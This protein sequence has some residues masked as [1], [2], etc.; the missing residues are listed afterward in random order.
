MAEQKRQSDDAIALLNVQLGMEVT[1]RKMTESQ[2]DSIIQQALDRQYAL[3]VQSMREEIAA[4][5]GNPFY[6]PVALQKLEDQLADI[7][8]QHQLAVSKTIADGLK[9]DEQRFNQFFNSINGD[10][11][12]MAN[13]M[14]SGQVT[15]GQ[16]FTRLGVQMEQA[17]IQALEK[18]VLKWVEQHLF[19]MITHQAWLAQLLGLDSANNATKQ[20][21]GAI[22]A[23]AAVTQQA[24]VAG[25]AAFA[26]VMASLP[27][28]ENVAAAP[29]AMAAA[30]SATM[31]NLSLASAAGGMEVPND[32]LAMVH[33]NEM[34]LPAGLSSGIKSAI[35]AQPGGG[36]A[37]P[38]IVPEQHTHLHVHAVDRGGV[39]RLFK[40]NSGELARTMRRAA[41]H[42][43]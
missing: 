34:V 3:R 43:K 25:A 19:M 2:K 28:P 42:G 39:Q 10:M 37:Q 38:G 11:T 36:R 9:S 14:I 27:F 26:S 33:K 35:G 6:D 40:N 1:E 22:A 41:R 5:Q 24:G 32:M 7:Q 16:G 8:R 23:D 20:A 21:Q 30:I 15:I 29:G 13:K 4:A 17:M 18:M 31:G 12:N